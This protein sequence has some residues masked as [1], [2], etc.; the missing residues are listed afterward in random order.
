[1]FTLKEAVKEIAL[2]HGWRATFM[3]R[4]AAGRGCCSGMH[5]GQ[6]LWTDGKNAFHD[7]AAAA[8]EEDRRQLSAV[9]RHWAAGLVKHAGALAALVSPTVNCYR[10]LHRPWAP[11]RADC[12]WQNRNAML[13]LVTS[14]AQTTYVENRLPSSAANPY[15]VLAATV[16]AG[17]DG[18]VNR[19]ELPP[20][21]AQDRGERLP[22][23]LSEALSA[24]ESDRTICDAL[25]DEFIRSGA[26]FSLLFNLGRSYLSAAVLAWLFVWSEVHTCICPS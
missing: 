18:L 14:S 2:E 6:S 7:D 5:F 21:D 9:G 3:T 13:R 12:G 25:G 24:L 8:E 15:V 23:S 10:R 1:M 11:D 19:L 20:A 22:S 26:T 16:A 17:V 4:P